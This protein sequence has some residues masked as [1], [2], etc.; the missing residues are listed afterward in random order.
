VTADE[1]PGAY[2]D[3]AASTPMHPEAVEAMLPWLRAHHA[4]P[5]GSHRA[6][7]EA[8]RA[9]DDA[10]DDLASILGVH[11]DEVVFTSGGT[12]SDN[13]AVLGGARRGD[14][15]AG[16]AVARRGVVASAVEHAAVLEAV[17]SVDGRLVGVD[18]AG[19]VDLER[20]ADALDDSTAVVSV[21][22]VNNEV[23]TIEPIDAVAEVVRSRAP[24]AVLHT[25]AVQ[26][27]PWIDPAPVAAQ[28]DALSLSA[29]KFGGPKGVGVLVWRRGVAI[30]PR[31]VGGGQERDRRAGTHNVAG[32]VGLATA[33]R[34]THERRAE[35]VARV[36]KLRDRLVDGILVSVDGVETVDRSLKVA[37]NAHL[38]FDGV[39]A[40]ALLFLLDQAGI[41]A[42]A[43]SSCASGAQ[44]PSHVLAAM[45]I[46]RARAAGSLRLT[47]GWST[48]EAEVD[49]AVSVVPA[50]VARLRSTGS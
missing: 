14:S 21:M 37:G 36:A 16:H 41:A 26:A 30:A 10:R 42:S 9:V 11:P 20:L 24:R 8:R 44:E 35:V 4:N 39:E 40:E 47:L 32:I 18:A 1:A 13:L 12:E 38:C 28:V 46:D 49:H 33:A 7:R 34:R 3:H 25:D 2:L 50:A 15:V 31:Q 6:A 5:S 23:G 22:A 19:V 48:T 43:A 17:A 27:F 45:G 29:H